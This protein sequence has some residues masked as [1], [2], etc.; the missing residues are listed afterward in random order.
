MYLYC[1]GGTQGPQPTLRVG[2]ETESKIIG[3]DIQRV[4]DWR[5]T[6]PLV[7]LNGCRTNAAEPQHAAAFLDV[8]VRYA[9]ASGMIG[10]EIVTY[11]RLAAGFAE[12]MLNAFVRNGQTMAASMRE[13]RLALLAQGNPLGLI[14]TAYAPPNLLM[15]STA[16]LQ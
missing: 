6:R 13:A 5:R 3:S 10:T 9:R 15:R 7:F 2:T 1:H 11:E 14:Y 16:E 8:F 4:A 12:V